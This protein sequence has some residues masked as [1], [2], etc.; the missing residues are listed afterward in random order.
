MRAVYIFIAVLVAFFVGGFVEHR[1]GVPFG[2][3]DSPA[4]PTSAALPP[5]PTES[6]VTAVPRGSNVRGL[7]D[8]Q[9]S[10]T[11]QG[12]RTDFQRCVNT[13]ILR[14]EPE[15]EARQVCQKIISGISG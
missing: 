3:I 12:A 15:A 4:L 5:V 8:A 1:L 13:M 14:R 2:R 9:R 6:G 11:P 10:D 7:E